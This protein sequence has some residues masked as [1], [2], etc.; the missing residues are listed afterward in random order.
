M[1]NSQTDSPKPKARR[2]LKIIQIAPLWFPVPPDRYGGTERVVASLCNSLVAKGHKVT[3]FASPGSQTKADLVSIYDKPLIEAGISWRNYLCNLNNLGKAYRLAKEG[4]Y[5]IIHS[6]L[7][8]LGIFFDSLTGIP[9]VHTMHNPLYEAQDKGK[10]KRFGRFN[11]FKSYASSL[12]MVFIS[13]AARSKAS[14]KFLKEEVIYNA[15]ET[16]KFPFYPNQEDHFIWIARISHSKGI[17]NAIEA[18]RQAGVKLMFAGRIDPDSQ[19]YFDTEIKP[20]LNSKIK[21]VGELSQ[22]ELPDFYGHAKALLYPIE[23][24]EPFGL[25]VAEAMSCGTP[26]IAF[27]KG[28]MPELVEDGKT[29]FVV[30]T[31][32]GLLAAMRKVDK[33]DRGYIFKRAQERWNIKRMVESYENF[34]YRICE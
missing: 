2:P 21:Y 25:V 7:D 23:W 32:R 31:M 26:V 9:T 11:I 12:N 1:A 20:K 28:S 6:H 15:V 16:E 14:L 27:K 19:K 3:L 30:K 4:K 33:L 10:T 29:G 34:Y 18:A 24:E 13:Q 22:K 5:D 8:I 17:E